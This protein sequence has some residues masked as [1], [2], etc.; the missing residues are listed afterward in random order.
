MAKLPRITAKQFAS[1][2]GADQIGIFGSLAA[3]SPTFTTSASAAQSLSNWLGGWFSGVEGENS[4]AIEDMNSFCYVMSS[5]L[6]YLY[7]TGIAEWDAGTTYYVGSLVTDV[8]AGNIYKSLTDNNLNNVLTSS[9]NWTLQGGNF[10]TVTVGTNITLAMGFIRSNST[11]A[12]LTHVLPAIS[13]IAIGAT[14]RIKDVG[15]GSNA[16]VIQGAGSDLIDGLNTYAA[17][18]NQYDSVTVF[19]NGAS[20]DVI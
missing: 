7:Q 19:N 3:G 10:T 16:T 5:L 4:P 6:C 9:A 2:A 14:V 11:S 15:T 20:W 13:S 8:G 18:I 17:N 12:S 1:A